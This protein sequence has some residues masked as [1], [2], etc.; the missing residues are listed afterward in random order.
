MKSGFEKIYY[1][2]IDAVCKFAKSYAP[3]VKYSK[4]TWQE[5]KEMAVKQSVNG[6]IGG[7]G[8]FTGFKDMAEKT[9]LRQLL[10]KWGEFSVDDGKIFDAD[11]HPSAIVQREEEFAEVKNV[12]TV[13][14]D[15]GEVVNA[16]EVHDEQPQQAQKFSL[17]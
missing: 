13:N 3:T 6:E 15:T 17:S 7:Y 10:D 11:E 16:E 1:M 9:V 4:V 12:I 5:L 2:T 14:A 8:W